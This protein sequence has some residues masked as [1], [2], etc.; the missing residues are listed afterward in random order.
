MQWL[1]DGRISPL[2]P[3]QR[4]SCDSGWGG[5]WLHRREHRE[6]PWPAPL[7]RCRY[8]APWE[9]VE[10]RFREI[11]GL[12]LPGGSGKLWYGHPFFDTAARLLDLARAENDA[13]GVFPV[14][15]VCL[16]FGG[17]LGS[18]PPRQRLCRW[19]LFLP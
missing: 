11:N 1:L 5:H 19:S 12:I 6:V 13:G 8:D 16:G 18:A 3:P 15:G 4:L 14:F 17:C 10:E 7:L 9:E 2:S